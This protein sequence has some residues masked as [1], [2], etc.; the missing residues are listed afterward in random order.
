[1]YNALIC[2][3]K[4]IALSEA[5]EI[6]LN[7]AL[8]LSGKEIKSIGLVNLKPN[9][10]A[11]LLSAKGALMQCLSA[12]NVTFNDYTA[13]TIAHDNLG[14]P[15]FQFNQS[16]RFMLYEKGVLDVFLSISD[17]KIVAFS[18]VVLKLDREKV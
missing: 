10:A 7:P 1:M 17:E 4:T 18:Y 8:L 3:T 13:V 5:L 11:K 6:S 9:L 15:Y 16:L 14:K 12:V 2:R